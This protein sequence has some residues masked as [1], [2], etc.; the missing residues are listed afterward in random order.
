MGTTSSKSA[1]RS[2]SIPSI[3]S[4]VSTLNLFTEKAAK[5]EYFT[6]LPEDVQ[7]EVWGYLGLRDKS[8]LASSSTVYKRLLSTELMSAKLLIQV[9]HGAQTRAQAMLAQYPD[10]SLQRGDVTDYSGR[11]FKNITAYEYAYWA[12]DTH[13][14]RMLEAHMDEATKAEMLARCETIERDGLS[15]KQHGVDKNSKH[16]DFEPLITAY[17]QYI[18]AYNSRNAGQGS[19]DAVRAA[20]MAVGVAQC[21]VPV[22]VINEYCRRD[23]RFHPR[24]SF[25]VT[26]DTLPRDVTYFDYRS[27]RDMAIFPLVVSDS[28][29]LGVD[30]ALFRIGAPSGRV[31]AQGCSSTAVA[32]DLAAVSRLNEVRTADVKQSLEILGKLNEPEH[33]IGLSR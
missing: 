26:G 18:E 1:G 5:F 28:S 9:A 8:A 22:H 13:M 21:D 6:R 23:R 31:V 10:L 32:V 27:S 25:E 14:C 19:Y 29:G 20:W 4:T 2:Q 7:K 16:F 30:F 11:I 17:T 24:P 15:Y 3:L 33:G 12:M